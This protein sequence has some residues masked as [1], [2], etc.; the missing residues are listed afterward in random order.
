M[1]TVSKVPVPSIEYSIKLTFI[2]LE[3]GKSCL[4][5]QY[6]RRNIFFNKKEI[7]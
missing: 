4:V 6:H 5:I 1:Q 3:N 7:S 2:V